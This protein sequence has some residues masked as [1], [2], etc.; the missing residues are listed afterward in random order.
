MQEDDEDAWI[1]KMRQDDAVRRKF[2]TPI[3]TGLANLQGL[4]RASEA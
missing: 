1:T 2:W 4:N 3:R